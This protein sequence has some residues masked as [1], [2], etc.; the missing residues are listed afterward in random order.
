[1]IVGPHP[2]RLADLA[3]TMMLDK[4]NGSA[5][6]TPPK[7]MEGEIV[8]NGARKPRRSGRNDVG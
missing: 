1:M 6:V 7:Y 8:W 3:G 2:G 5:A 4:L